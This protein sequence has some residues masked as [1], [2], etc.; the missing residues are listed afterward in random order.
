MATPGL[1]GHHGVALGHV[2]GALLVAD[3]DV[4][5]GGVDDRVVD[6]QD[7]AAG[8]AEHDVD[9]LHLEALDEGLGP[10]HLHV[11]PLFCCGAVRCLVGRIGPE[12]EKTPRIGRS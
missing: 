5:D 2:A 6:G 3:Q 7:G 11:L 12:I 4:A 8:Q 10:C 9:P 1:P